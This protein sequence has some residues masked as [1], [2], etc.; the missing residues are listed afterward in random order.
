MLSVSN[1]LGLLEK[2]ESTDISINQHRCVVV[3]NRNI[4]CRRCAE[5]CT[6]GC[7]DVRNGQLHLEPERC[8]GCGTCATVC[9]SGAITP[10]MPDDAEL[11]A[12]CHAAQGAAR[13]TAI[14][15]CEQVLSAARG[16]YDPEKVVGVTCLG[17]V[18][19]SVLMQLV[20]HGAGSVVLVQGDCE[21]C[22]RACGLKTAQLVMRTTNALLETWSLE[23]CVEIE[24]HLP[25]AAQSSRDAQYD[26]GRRQ[27]FSSFKSKIKAT[28]TLVTGAAAEEMVG[29]SDQT[30]QPEEPRV[31]KVAADGTLPHF[32]PARRKALLETLER[33]GIPENVLIAT[34][35]WGH[36]IID[37][38]AC[39]SCQMC[40]TFCPTG[41]LSKIE[42]KDG[43]FGL[44]HAPA[45][46]VKCR[47]CQDVCRTQ[48]LSIS[49]EVFAV[50]LLRGFV[51]RYEL[52]TPAVEKVGP[53]S[54]MD[55][56]RHILGNE[57]IYER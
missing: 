49:D 43:T 30:E 17:R 23:A 2:L 11:F 4:K 27:F 22:T 46:C 24:T 9:P 13:G 19:E 48:A 45:V 29:A 37:S 18:D 42:D 52:A 21:T 41:A 7:I 6:T 55:N 10:K 14:I 47:S 16:E 15:A 31:I 40:A 28:A 5:T 51:E 35:L 26:S 32:I 53:H 57:R 38:T 3:R 33:S 20:E 44:L 36:V 25:S 50:D 34:R 54:A 39:T 1:I 12:T 56:M 8:I